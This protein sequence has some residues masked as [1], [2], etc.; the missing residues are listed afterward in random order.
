MEDISAFYFDAVKNRLYLEPRASEARQSCQI[1]LVRLYSDLMRIS[2]PIVP[3]LAAEV[4][5]HR[6]PL[7]LPPQEIT[8]SLP[9]HHHWECLKTI[10]SAVLS[11]LNE[12]RANG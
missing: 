6:P 8:T 7:P 2:R 3:F 1:A 9:R 4:D 11:R 12:L 10:R 5:S